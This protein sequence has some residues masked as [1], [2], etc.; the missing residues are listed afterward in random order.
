M[1]SRHLSGGC[2]ACWNVAADGEEVML[3]LDL[4]PVEQ[5]VLRSMFAPF[6]A[7]F[8]QGPLEIETARRRRRR[9]VAREQAMRR[10]PAL[11]THDEFKYLRSIS[12]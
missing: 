7:F 6:R 9:S 12:S 11:M 2:G 4:V 8:K 1:E 5:D 10:R 3:T